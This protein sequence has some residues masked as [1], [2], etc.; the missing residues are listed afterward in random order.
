MVAKKTSPC[1]ANF[2]GKFKLGHDATSQTG[3]DVITSWT[4]ARMWSRDVTWMAR[5]QV[6]K[7]HFS[8]G[9]VTSRNHTGIYDHFLERIFSQESNGISPRI[10]R[11]FPGCTRRAKGK[12]KV[13]RLPNVTFF[14]FFSK[15]S[16]H[17][18]QEV[19]EEEDI[20]W[21]IFTSLNAWIVINWEY[22][23]SIIKW[24]KTWELQKSHA[25]F[26]LWIS[27]LK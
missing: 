25:D 14:I 10:V 23:L 19:L 17:Y 13:D 27:R 1:K 22:P 4:Y 11:S 26:P 18:G 16:C 2:G 21:I 15:S 9:F 3:A 12:G 20:K 24:G 6:A 7:Y 5:W 8:H